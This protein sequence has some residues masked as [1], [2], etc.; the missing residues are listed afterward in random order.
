VSQ[1]LVING[2]ILEVE[3][4]NTPLKRSLGLMYRSELPFNSG[5]L[6]VFPQSKNLSFW[7]KDTH[8]PLSIAYID[9]NGFIKNIENMNPED[10]T[11]IK[12]N[13]PCK[14]AL[15]V[16]QG[17]FEKNKIRTGDKVMWSHE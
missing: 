17:W 14:F 2:N 16:N 6:F 5:M 7:M 1:K 3:L 8:I 9:E 10:I 15:E 12:S 4:A 13:S 11:S